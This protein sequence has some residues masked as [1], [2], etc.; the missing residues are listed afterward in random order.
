MG[1]VNALVLFVRYNRNCV[2]LSA[3]CAVALSEYLAQGADSLGLCGSTVL[4]LGTGTAFVGIC[5]AFLGAN[6]IAT[7]LDIMLPLARENIRLNAEGISTGEGS[8]AVQCCKW[9]EPVS[10]LLEGNTARSHTRISVHDCPRVW[11]RL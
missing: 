7:D 2:L 8:V 10:Q 3:D 11:Q 1:Y 5:A 6:V 4:E 9:G